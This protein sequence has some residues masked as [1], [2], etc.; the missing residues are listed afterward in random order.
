M[1]LYVL[2]LH[3]GSR[4]CRKS[5]EMVGGFLLQDVDFVPIEINVMGR[6]S[7]RK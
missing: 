6:V 2:L 1:H 7:L 5:T 3:H 4:L